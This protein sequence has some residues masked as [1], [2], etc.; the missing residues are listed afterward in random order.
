MEFLIAVAVST[1][2]GFLAGL[3]VGGGS[4]LMLYL[5]LVLGWAPEEARTVNLLFFLP[6]A[7][8]ATLLRRKEG[9]VNLKQLIP[10]IAAGCIAGAAA[11]ILGKGLDTQLLK[12]IFGVLL[13]AVGIREIL[14]KEKKKKDG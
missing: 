4:L 12:K 1:V 2:L 13:L 3:G 7:A 10:A 9:A 14:Y 8:I 11:S 6:S 5:T